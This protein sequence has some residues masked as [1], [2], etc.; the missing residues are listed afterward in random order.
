MT[1]SEANGTD[2]N[3]FWFHITLGHLKA[4]GRRYFKEISPFLTTLETLLFMNADQR[5]QNV[6]QLIKSI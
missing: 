2:P 1:Q 4:T 3:T 5:L 6:F